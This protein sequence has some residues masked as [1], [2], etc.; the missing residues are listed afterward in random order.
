MGF[1]HARQLARV[2]RQRRLKSGKIETETIW[3]ISSLSAEQAGPPR[4]LEL[5][6]ACWGIENGTHRSLDP[7]SDEDRCRVRHPEGATVLGLLRRW[8]P[9]EARGWARGQP[10]SRART[11]PTFLSRQESDRGARR[12]PAT[13]R[14]G[15]L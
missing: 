5:A 4:L 1:P 9:G 8:L 14:R 10:R 15:G 13:T 7:V 3:L 2:D 6:R 12:R 11:C